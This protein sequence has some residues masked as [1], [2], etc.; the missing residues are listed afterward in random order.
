MLECFL[1]KKPESFVMSVYNK[2]VVLSFISV[3]L[4]L[5]TTEDNSFLTVTI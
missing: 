2:I 4:F 3:A 5:T 1:K